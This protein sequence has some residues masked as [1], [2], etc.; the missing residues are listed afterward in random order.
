M[1]AIEKSVCKS[2]ND[3]TIIIEL[4]TLRVLGT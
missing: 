1:F 3:E 2:N 4:N